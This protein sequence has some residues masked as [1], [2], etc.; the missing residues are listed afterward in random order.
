MGP[1]KAKEIGQCLWSRNNCNSQGRVGDHSRAK[2]L[3][4]GCV[5]PQPN[6]EALSQTGKIWARERG[7]ILEESYRTGDG[8]IRKEGEWQ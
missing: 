6:R 4:L 3:A 5:V 2:V 1:A 8:T 7:S